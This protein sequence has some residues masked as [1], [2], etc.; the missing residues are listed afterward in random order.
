MNLVIF[1]RE[2]DYG[3]VSSVFIKLAQGLKYSEVN[4]E[5]IC[6]HNKRD[7]KLAKVLETKTGI[8]S[9]I[10]SL[11][12]YLY[13]NK[14]DVIVL[15]PCIHIIGIKI[16]SFIKKRRI[17]V[18]TTIHMRPKF[19]LLNRT[20]NNRITNILTRWSVKISDEVI[21]VSNDLAK[22][23]IQMNIINQ[24]KIT[25]IYNPIVEEEV[26]QYLKVDIE[27]KE[28]IELVMIGW[29]YELKGQH[30]AIEALNHL[31]CCKYRL[32][33]IGE[34]K[35]PLYY[36]LLLDMIDKYNLKSQVNF[37]GGVENIKQY[38]SKM[39]LLIS[40]SHSEALPTVLIEA[41]ELGIPVIASNCKWGPSEILE[42]G[43][44]GLLYPVN[45]F[46]KLSQCISELTTCNLKY[47]SFRTIAHKRANCF[48]KTNIINQYLDKISSTL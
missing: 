4:T 29:I 28:I 45:D 43:K 18:I 21:S 40:A 13:Y 15:S 42:D 19:W 11:I 46:I 48:L 37:I 1:N 36:N 27:E 23:L 8:I 16:F 35:D 14:I 26:F 6:F 31:N 22:E 30:I 47:N 20:F 25:T 34:I 2:L 9:E 3:G 17:K 33:I 12:R 41:L 24:K 39:D 5:L 7:I 32:N 44:Y 10:F 38:L